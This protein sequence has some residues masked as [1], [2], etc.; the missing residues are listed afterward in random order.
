MRGKHSLHAEKQS[1]ETMAFK[2]PWDNIFEALKKIV[3]NIKFNMNIKLSPKY[4]QNKE[5][6]QKAKAE[7]IYLYKTCTTRNYLKIH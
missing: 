7:K 4:I 1:S 5:F 3:D 2:R 6:F